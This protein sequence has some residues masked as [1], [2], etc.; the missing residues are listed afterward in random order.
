M[1]YAFEK[2]MQARIPPG[3]PTSVNSDYIHIKQ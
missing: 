3:P 1:A 2:I